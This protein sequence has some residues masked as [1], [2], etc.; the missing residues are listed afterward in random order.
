MSRT[1]RLRHEYSRV[2]HKFGDGRYS[3]H[4]DAID[5]DLSA[6]IVHGIY[7]YPCG[8][9]E[10]LSYVDHKFCGVSCI[11]HHTVCLDLLI[12]SWGMVRNVLDKLGGDK[13]YSIASLWYH[14]YAH[15]KSSVHKKFKWYTMKGVRLGCNTLVRIS[16]NLNNFDGDWDTKLYYRKFCW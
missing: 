13:R 3:E 12:P 9:M 2:A 16:T 11:S 6:I 1:Y 5:N 10:P 4:V 7:G 8:L 14:K 15:P